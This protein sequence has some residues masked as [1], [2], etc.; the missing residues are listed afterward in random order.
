MIGEIAEFA[1]LLARKRWS[2]DRLESLRR[3]KL[4][5]LIR[6]AYQ[7]V[8]YYRDLMKREGIEPQ[9]IREASDLARF[10][11][12]TKRQLREA[13]SLALA[14]ATRDHMILETS[15][16]SGV[17]FNVHLSAAEYRTRRLREFRMLIGVGVRPWDRLTLLGA[18]RTRPSRLHR[19]LGLYR[20]DVIPCTLPREEVLERLIASRP[21]VLWVYP[22][23][24]KMALDRDWAGL[25][26]LAKPRLMITSAS[27]MEES[28]RNLLLASNP[29][30]VI[31]DIYGSAEAGRIAAACSKRSGLHLEEDALIVELLDNGREVPAGELGA[32]VVTCLDQYAAPLIRYEQGDLCRRKL[33]PC[34]CPWKTTLIEPPAGRNVDMIELPSGRRLQAHRTI[35]AARSESQ[36]LQFRFV[37]R[38]TDRIDAELVFAQPPGQDE[39]DRLQR[40]LE[41]TLEE[42]VMVKIHLL[43]EANFTGMKFKVFVSELENQ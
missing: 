6:H 32:T 27:V 36:L 11:V 10:P 7:H 38:T 3:D 33:A 13:A 28:F 26:K 29:A 25:A 5:R 35:V 22:T 42:G 21:D 39:I 4:Q 19:R 20:M 43:S 2:R 37:Q 18:I 9:D 34:S 40:S 24:L 14:S 30:L 31:A 17:P 1:G 12:T 15:G 16:H 23:V 8:P 41:N